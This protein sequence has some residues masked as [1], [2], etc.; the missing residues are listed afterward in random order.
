MSSSAALEWRDVNRVRHRMIPGI[1]Q[2]QVVAGIERLF[3]LL[4]DIMTA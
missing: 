1:V 3:E 2:L 4:L